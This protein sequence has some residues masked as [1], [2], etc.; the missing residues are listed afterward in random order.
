M[1]ESENI[2]EEPEIEDTK[3]VKLDISALSREETKENKIEENLE[4]YEPIPTTDI[5]ETHSE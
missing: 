2:E 1:E 5:N 3:K 4:I